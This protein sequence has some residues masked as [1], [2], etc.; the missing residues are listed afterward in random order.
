MRG[1]KYVAWLVILGSLAGAGLVW[2][3]D[4][5]PKY[6]IKQVMAQAHKNGMYKKVAQ[7]KA[8]KEE[9]DKLVELYTA[10]RKKH[11]AQGGRCRLEEA[12]R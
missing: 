4:S 11:S 1:S 5:K 10:R 6:T 2:G 12:N 7:G 3:D 9:K 8:T